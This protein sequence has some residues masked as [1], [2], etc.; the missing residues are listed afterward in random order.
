MADIAAANVTYSFKIKD[1]MYLGRRGYS[2]RGTI[3]FGNGSL[4]YPAG[5]I[6]LTK[7]KMGC[8]RVL[9]S[10]KIFESNAK[11]L[12]FEHDVSAETI[13]IFQAD[14]PTISLANAGANAD[15]NASVFSNAG[16]LSHGIAAATG[17]TGVQKHT[18]VELTSAGNASLMDTIVLEVEAE[19]Y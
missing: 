19:G 3:T 15:A 5:G 2:S 11:N 9:R 7:G 1:K 10:V 18:L 12:V 14:A 6:P 4:N 13:R 16:V 8:P 17:V